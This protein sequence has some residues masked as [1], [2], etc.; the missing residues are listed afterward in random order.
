MDIYDVTHAVN[1]RQKRGKQ[2]DTKSQGINPSMLASEINVA[3]LLQS[4][5]ST[6]RSTLSED[7]LNKMDENR[8]ADGYYS[9]R[10]RYSY[11]GENANNAD[12]DTLAR[13]KEM[14]ATGVA[15]ETIRQQTGWFKGMDGKWRW[16]IDDSKMRYARFVDCIE[17]H[18][19]YVTIALKI[20]PILG[21]RRNSYPILNKKMPP[22]DFHQMV[23]WNGG[24][25]GN[26]LH[27]RQSR[28]LGFR[29]VEPSRAMLVRVALNCSIP[30]QLTN[31]KSHPCGWL[32]LGSIINVGVR[33]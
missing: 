1:G 23:A 26:R 6:Y 11:A 27:L 14:K 2:V 25:E 8:N 10:V 29:S 9:G 30:N 15:D 19:G 33:R 28:K 18:E 16:E 3:D 22:L 21:Y 17:V 32:L 7:V 31:N 5:K 24:A 20:L 12:L 4:V 13:A